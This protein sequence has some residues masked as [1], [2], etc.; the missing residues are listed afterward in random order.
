MLQN[1]TNLIAIVLMAVNAQYAAAV[2]GLIRTLSRRRFLNMGFYRAATLDDLAQNAEAE[3]TVTATEALAIQK[4]EV[5]AALGAAAVVDGLWV[6]VRVGDTTVIPSGCD[7]TGDGLQADADF[8]PLN[9][10]NLAETTG[11]MLLLLT[12]GAGNQSTEAIVTIV[13]RAAG[14][15]NDA[16]VVVHGARLAPQQY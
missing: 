7:V 1:V 3:F 16:I 10:F 4:I 9:V 15:V 2:R 8:I 11:Q 12:P 14:A 13:N 5:F 6:K